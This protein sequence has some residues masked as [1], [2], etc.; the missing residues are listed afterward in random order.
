MPSSPE[1]IRRRELLILDTGPIWELVLFHA[2]DQFGFERLRQELQF[3]KDQSTYERCV[4]F[5]ALFKTKTTSASVVAELGY[6][7]RKTERGGQERLWNRVFE[8]FQSMGMDEEV[9]R[10]VQMNRVLV[11]RMGPVDVSLLELA[12]R[13][14]DDLPVVLTVDSALH[15][16][17]MKAGLRVSLLQ[18]LTVG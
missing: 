13:H 7:I 18:Q 14:A 2:V 17:C 15:S 4:E 12:R 6:Q 8:E 5:I 11:A 1:P 16:E 3:I 10:L 9:I